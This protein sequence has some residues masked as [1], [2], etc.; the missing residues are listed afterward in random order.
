MPHHTD[1]NGLDSHIQPSTFHGSLVHGFGREAD[2]LAASLVRRLNLSP[3]QHDDIRQDLL[4][5]LF[6]RVKYFDPARGRWEAFVGTVLWHGAVRLVQRIRRERSLFSSLSL[7]DPLPDD[8][9]SIGELIAETGGYLALMGQDHDCVAAAEHRRDVDRVIGRLGIADRLFCAG[10]LE[11]TPTELSENG[12]RSRASL[13][14]QL[15]DVR[16]QMVSHG[17]SVAA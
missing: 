4:V 1:S 8:G 15:Q 10:L 7:N 12:L 16:F 13:Y 14:R 9:G 6:S 2:R 3:C 17:L 5:E 11:H